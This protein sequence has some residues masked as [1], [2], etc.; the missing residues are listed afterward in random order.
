M[1]DEYLDLR[2]Q[3]EENGNHAQL[4]STLKDTAMTDPSTGA[5]DQTTASEENATEWSNNPDSAAAAAA[6]AAAAVLANGVN[7][8]LSTAADNNPP[9][10]FPTLDGAD[11]ESMLGAH[12]PMTTTALSNLLS[13]QQQQQGQTEFIPQV[14]PGF[15][16]PEQ[17]LLTTNQQQ[18]KQQQQDKPKEQ[19]K[20]KEDVTME[21]AKETGKE[22]KEE[23]GKMKTRSSARRRRQS[24]QTPEEA[25]PKKKARAK[26][27]YCICQ[28]PYDGE[29]MVQCDT[30]RDW[31]HCA[32]LNL[33]ADDVENMDS[34][35]CN[36]CQEKGVKEKKQELQEEPEQEPKPEEELNKKTRQARASRK[37]L[38]PPCINRTRADSYCSDVCASQDALR[39]SG[40]SDYVPEEENKGSASPP[41]SNSSSRR[42]STTSDTK[43]SRKTKSTPPIRSNVA[44][45]SP[46]RSNS[47]S[48][49]TKEA[50]PSQEGFNADENP[51][52]KNVIKNMT[53]L[54]KS[55]M[56][57][58]ATATATAATATA[59]GTTTTTSTTDVAA[60]DNTDEKKDEEKKEEA[61]ASEL[62]IKIEETMYEE[63]GDPHASFA[64]TK[65]RVCGER[66]K[67][68]FRTLLHNLKDKANETFRRRVVTGELTPQDLVKMTSEDMAN[69]ELRT[70]SESLR[71]KALKNTILKQ[72]NVPLIKKT[73]KGDIEMISHH[74]D[75][76]SVPEPDRK[77][78]RTFHPPP[79]DPPQQP[80][81]TDAEAEEM[82]AMVERMLANSERE[83]LRKQEEEQGAENANANAED[84]APYDP[85]NPT[86]DNDVPSQQFYQ[87]EDDDEQL[88]YDDQGN[89]I[90]R[91]RRTESANT[92]PTTPPM[93]P[94][95]ESHL[96]PVVW[97]GRVNMPQESDFAAHARQIGGRTLSE[98]EWQDVLS[99]TM[100]VEGRIRTKVVTDY[101]NQMQYSSSRE[102]V[103]L[104]IRADSPDDYKKAQYLVNYF[105]KRQRYGVVGRNKLKIKD[106]YL[107]PLF[108]GQHLPDC[109]YVVR[110][111]ETER[112]VDVF[113]GVLVISR[114]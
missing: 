89:M 37:C 99:P 60:M 13:Q 27:L 22:D 64:Q 94:P 46:S 58:T 88:E 81:A 110:V 14:T 100:W 83:R 101:V 49:D 25:A 84:D 53:T 67:H 62:A 29:P 43:K 80:A 2:D 38:Y 12:S 18:Q 52:R 105:D 17:L 45:N 20:D 70:M 87:D 42:S 114:R 39:K 66:Y 47:P 51:I 102:I 63:L 6:A 113:L 41:E 95:A 79:I 76:Q 40:D 55:I 68:K 59:A 98:A 71:E 9:F 108:K 35:L 19:G 92:E 72:E 103:L 90:T 1:F 5:T 82:E 97:R 104:E 54:L 34:W 107:L 75:I 3:Q 23:D 77:R 86:L 109:V 78:I 4:D 96:P 61:E 74:D 69:P 111:D 112:D 31:Y 57:T 106:F 33:D 11:W 15:V 48:N 30:C 36:N 50:S 7:I 10:Y 65:G 24:Q 21:D 32:C 91:R 56:T 16:P 73:H 85:M 44:S 8:P 28:K 93:P 26:K